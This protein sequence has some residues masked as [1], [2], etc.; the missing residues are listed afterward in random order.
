LA[1]VKPP[2]FE[3]HVAGSQDEALAL[4]AEHGEDAKVLAGG[5]SLVPLLA[6]RLAQPAQLVDISRIRELATISDGATV[7]DGNGLRIGAV[8]RQRTVERSDD[9]ARSSPL[10]AGAV[11]FIGHAAIRNRGTIGG[12]IAH[13][14][15]AAELPAVL[16][17]LDGEVELASA[18]GTRRVA[19]ADLYEGFLTTVLEPDELLTAV[20]LPSL[21]AGTGWAFHEFSRRSGDFAIAGVACTLRVDGGAVAE[22]RIAL[23]GMDQTPVRATA[24]EA[25]LVG[26]APS[27]ELWAAAAAAAVADLR[28][29]SDLHGTREYRRHLAGVLIRRAL[30]EAYDR[31]QGDV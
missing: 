28:P 1:A 19:A 14:D 18:R 6:L 2:P 11:R 3:Y 7:T 15:P 26:Q 22:A 9:V 29:P 25:A 24:G 13:G 31:T 27:A 8:V 17:A 10:L 12:S 5:Q 20:H 30:V 21:P 23:S 16:V 4:L